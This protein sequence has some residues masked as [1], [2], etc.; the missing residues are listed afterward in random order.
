MKYTILAAT[1]NWVQGGHVIARVT[2]PDYV[3]TTCT[4]A[5]NTVMSNFLE[6]LDSCATKAKVLAAENLVPQPSTYGED[7]LFYEVEYGLDLTWRRLEGAEHEQEKTQER[8]DSS[9]FDQ[10]ID[11]MEQENRRLWGGGMCFCNKGNCDFIC[12]MYCTRSWCMNR[13]NLRGIHD[14]VEAETEEE[15]AEY[16]AERRLLTDEKIITNAKTRFNNCV[17]GKIKTLD[18]RFSK[19]CGDALKTG[20]VVVGLK[21]GEFVCQQD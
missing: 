21:W 16:E 15:Q 12:Q 20:T 19:E 18:W 10:V 1:L 13:R 17:E 6:S 4:D 7:D 3:N 14:E 2:A 5:D 11:P 8:E 9:F